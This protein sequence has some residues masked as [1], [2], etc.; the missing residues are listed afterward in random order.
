MN[1]LWSFGIPFF[2]V[3]ATTVL[4]WNGQAVAQMPSPVVGG[5]TIGT[6]E[7]VAKA[8]AEGQVVYYTSNAEEES[9]SISDVFQQQFPCIKVLTVSIV[10]GRLIERVLTEFQAGKVQADVA[11]MSD[12]VVLQDFVD[13]KII[14]PWNPP[15]A[16]KYPATGQLKGWWYAA[17]GSMLYPIY[18]TQMVSEA[19]A[20]KSLKDLLDPKWKG[21]IAA[22]SILVGGTGW[23][24]Y[25]IFVEKYG[26]D[27]LKQFAAQQPKIFTSY[28]PMTLA[29]ARGELPIG[30]ISV[31]SEYPLRKQGAPIKPVYPA[32]GIP[33]VPTPM[34][35]LANSSHPN[36]AELFG[37]WSLSKA[38]QERAVEVRGIWSQR[39]DVAVA[40]GNPPASQMNFWNP[41]TDVILKNYTSFIEK[42][43]RTFDGR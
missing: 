32:E 9:R 21:K 28:A 19:D 34:M 5:E 1:R 17:A 43:Q 24:Q 6:P 2:G 38:G 33:I 15:A 18:N 26:D 22:P 42:V 36:A 13:K 27:F 31:T 35:M 11:T 3:L 29:V 40:K 37:N 12:L 41:G 30:L 10:T 7:L 8:C 20:P 16:D 4:G 39:T 25:Y 23:L 14:R